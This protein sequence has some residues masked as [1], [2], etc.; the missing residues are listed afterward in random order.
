VDQGNVQVTLGVSMTL[1]A[2]A[3]WMLLAL[4]VPGNNDFVIGSAS[5]RSPL[6]GVGARVDLFDG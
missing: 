3:T 6:S 4:W 2:S 5:T 1:A